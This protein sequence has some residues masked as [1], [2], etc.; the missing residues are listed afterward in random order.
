MEGSALLRGFLLA[1]ESSADEFR[2]KYDKMSFADKYAEYKTAVS[3][4]MPSTH[5]GADVG[6]LSEYRKFF[7]GQVE[8]LKALHSAYQDAAKAQ[9]KTTVAVL[10]AQKPLSSLCIEEAPF[11][12]EAGFHTLVRSGSLAA[13]RQHRE[14]LEEAPAAHY[15]VLVAAT[16]RELEDTEAAQEALQGLEE[17]QKKFQELRKRAESLE[18]SKKHL[19]DGGAPPATFSSFFISKDKNKE[20]SDTRDTLAQVNEDSTVAQEWFAMAGAI[21]LSAEIPT[22]LSRSN[23]LGHWAAEQF[24]SRSTRSSERLRE[25]WSSQA[26]APT[27]DASTF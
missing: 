2:Q 10:S 19:E 24:A 22:H 7:E 3:Q 14:V 23:E 25:L 11:M 1:S 21:G 8:R 18:A 26:P 27:I 16:D 13:F 4:H 15:D 9:R 20:L 6:K 17:L 12:K 5:A